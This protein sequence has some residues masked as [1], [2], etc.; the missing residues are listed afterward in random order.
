M[1][2]KGSGNTGVVSLWSCLLENI[3]AVAVVYVIKEI[4]CNLNKKYTCLIYIEVVGWIGMF[5]LRYG[6]E[7]TL[8]GIIDRLSVYLYALSGFIVSA[9]FI[10][11]SNI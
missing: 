10:G 9:I 5:L 4:K 11:H 1:V 7:G 2:Y 8:S 6:V 3:K